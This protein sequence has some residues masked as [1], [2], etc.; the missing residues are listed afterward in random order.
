[1]DHASPYR[2]PCPWSYD[3]DKVN[4]EPTTHETKLP[5]KCLYEKEPGEGLNGPWSEVLHNALIETRELIIDPSSDYTAADILSKLSNDNETC[6]DAILGGTSTGFKIKTYVASY[7]DK[8][9]VLINI[10]DKLLKGRFVVH[11]E[12]IFHTWIKNFVGRVFRSTVTSKAIKLAA[13]R[14]TTGIKA[15]TT[16]VEHLVD[17]GELEWAWFEATFEDG[18]HVVGVPDKFEPPPAIAEASE[19]GSDSGS[20]NDDDNSDSN[21]D[22]DSNEGSDEEDS[23]SFPSDDSG[24]EE[25]EEK[26]REE[27]AKRGGSQDE[28]G[29]HVI[30]SKKRSRQG[31]DDGAFD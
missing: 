11:N 26:T 8:E 18:K 14:L 31:E 12:Q 21:N 15:N 29:T 9:G 16:A 24:A 4:H 10:H 5:N 2:E 3:W 17:S 19:S 7:L 1:M 6:I 27:K 22:S 20:D 28:N 23:E 13:T 25:A 30:K